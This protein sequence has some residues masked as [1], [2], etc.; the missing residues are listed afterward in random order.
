MDRLED[1]IRDYLAEHLDLLESGLEFVEK[2]YPLPSKIG[3]GGRIDLLAK[4]SFG[5]RV[6]IEIKRADQ[7]ARQ[8]LHEIHK[9]IALFRGSQ[10]LD[11]SRIRLIVVSTTWHELLLPL[12][13]FAATTPYSVDGIAIT[14][15]PDGTITQAT[16]VS[17]VDINKSA[18]F[19]FSRIQAIYLY[20]IAE[21]R[22]QSEDK[23][24]AAIQ[25]AGVEDFLILRCSYVG[26]NPIAFP[27]ALYVCFSSPFRHLPPSE[28]ESLKTRIEWEEELDEP[29][30][31][32][33]VA[34]NAR[35]VDFYDDFEIGYPE[36]LTKILTEWS[37]LLSVRSGRFAEGKSTLTD[38]ELI[39]LAQAV[40][41][42]SPIYFAKTSS[43]RFEASWESLRTDLPRVLE[44]NK[45]WA[46]IV[47]RYI[48]EIAAKCPTASVSVSIYNPANLL[49]A[50]YWIA[51]NED[52]SKCPTLE[53]IIED[54]ATKVIRILLGILVWN[55][56]EIRA[57][58]EEIIERVYGD[59]EHWLVSI[60]F[61]ST[62]ENESAA[63]SAHNLASFC[64]E[65]QF[66]G[67]RETGPIEVLVEN[68]DLCRRTFNDE[69]HR[70][71]GE[72]CAENSDYLADL[73]TQ[74]QKVVVGLPGTD[75]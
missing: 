55:G 26:Q 73:Q 20:S 37:V 43:P 14:A 46:D 71:F 39:K 72:F 50:L 16:K 60:S 70:P 51:W 21:T 6:I 9:Y 62:A 34:A 52:Y 58:P 32:F 75:G 44:G 66:E 25:S 8:A 23:L 19:K 56:R 57:T 42:G 30:E 74:I 4:D 33:M 2:E 18:A 68:G 41:G 63:L 45:G 7:S 1:K 10:G 3:A 49:M 40:D 65:W 13:E 27:Y 11:E 22:D 28:A 61:G 69:S 35:M 29:D 36:K 24:I 38:E 15:L 59:L 47:P 64:V 48:D 67:G 54:K 17:L 12:S 5:H 53:I 31:N